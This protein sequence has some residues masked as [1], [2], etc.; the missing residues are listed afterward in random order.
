MSPLTV[1]L[2]RHGRSEANES[3]VI[4]GGLDT[5]LAPQ[6][7]AQAAA[8]AELVGSR[9]QPISAIYASPL[10]RALA[11]AAP[12]AEQCGVAVTVVAAWRELSFGSLEGA[13]RDTDPTAQAAYER[14]RQDPR[15]APAP[16]AESLA[17]LEARV[18]PAL[19]AVLAEHHNGGTILVV[20]HNVTNRVLLGAL[21]G[22]PQADYASLSLRSRHLYELTLGPTPTLRTFRLGGD[23]HGA[24]SEGFVL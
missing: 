9:P 16:G 1:L 7:Q 13:N 8:L 5:P 22:W 6:G 10:Q 19:A 11:T 24:V 12:T 18:R 20:G 21:A 3:R 2:V 4:A 23:R 15:P 14:W 17:D